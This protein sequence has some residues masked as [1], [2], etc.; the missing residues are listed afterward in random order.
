M[1]PLLAILAAIS[2][3]FL[4][5]CQGTASNDASAASTTGADAPEGALS[6]DPSATGG[7]GSNTSSPTPSGPKIDSVYSDLDPEK[8]ETIESEMEGYYSKQKCPG[9]FGYHLEV[10]ESD[11]RQTVNVVET[12]GKS[13]ELDLG[14]IVS[15]AFSYVG[16]K[17]EWRFRETD[18]NRQPFALIIRFNASVDPNSNKEA[19]YLT[20]SKIT[21]DRICVTD[22][23]KPIPNANVEARK[24]AEKAAEKPCLESK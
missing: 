16:N 22:V 4:I 8:C 1:K 12:S 20:V 5:G 2:L 15:R 18:G 21:K 10:I 3:S 13:H 11:I 14:G 23:V 19:S 17:A 6:G 24:L 7:D 9:A